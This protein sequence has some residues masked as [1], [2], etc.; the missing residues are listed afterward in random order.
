MT[1][2]GVEWGA[3]P[4]IILLHGWEGRGSQ[5][6]AFAE[7]LTKAGFRVAAFDAP[8]HGRS[9]GRQ[10]SLPHFAW[11]LRGVADA[12]GEVHGVIGHSLGCAAAT[13]AMSDGLA[14]PRAVFLSPPLNPED[15]TRQFG[16]MFGLSDDVIDGPRARIEERFVRVANVVS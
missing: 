5:L 8:G 12:L 7:P 11:A 9:S 10:S 15:Y 4:L 3:G 13:L 1:L 6:A 14:I 2:R 16:E